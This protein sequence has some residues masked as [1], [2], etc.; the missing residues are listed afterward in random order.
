MR[1]PEDENLTGDNFADLYQRARAGDELS[2]GKLIANYRSY[3]LLIANEELDPQIQT[4]VAPS[5]VVQLSMMSA[6]TNIE[7]FEG[8][9]EAQFRGWI[10]KILKNDVHDVRRKY[11]LAK[12]RDFTRERRIDDSQNE[13]IM[14]AVKNVNTPSTDAQ[15]REQAVLLHEAIEQLPDDYRTVVRLRNWEEKSFVEIGE[16]LDCNADAAR[17]LWYRAV[18]KLESTI[19]RSYPGLQSTI[20]Q[21]M[22]TGESNDE[23]ETT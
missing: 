19:K 12:R 1:Q 10:R 21:L 5:D 7:Q 16:L 8:T 23:Q 15:L 22:D 9:T 18:V 3:L 13:K 2:L 14:L 20:I 6:Q 11:Q 4:K 17:K